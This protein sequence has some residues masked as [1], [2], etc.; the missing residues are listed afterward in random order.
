[1]CTQSLVSK[2]EK[3]VPKAWFLRMRNV[4]SKR[5]NSCHLAII[6]THYLVTVTHALYHPTVVIQLYTVWQLSELLSLLSC[7]KGISWA[8]VGEKDHLKAVS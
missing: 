8:R 7:D 1:M 2:D 4:Y 5:G 3:C 6:E